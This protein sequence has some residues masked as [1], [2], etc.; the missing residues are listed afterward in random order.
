[1]FP[2]TPTYQAPTLRPLAPKAKGRGRMGSSRRQ[3][4]NRVARGAAAARRKPRSTWRDAL[5]RRAAPLTGY[6]LKIVSPSTRST[7]KITTKT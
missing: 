7:R 3:F 4:L 6:A 2:P 5:A 1:M